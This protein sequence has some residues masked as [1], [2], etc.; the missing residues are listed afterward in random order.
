M[1]KGPIPVSVGGF[2]LCMAD[3]G[4]GLYAPWESIATTAAGLTS[5][6]VSGFD[7]SGFGYRE[8]E[9]TIARVDRVMP[10]TVMA[11]IY[12]QRSRAFE[13]KPTRIYRTEILAAV[14]DLA[15]AVELEAKL[16]QIGRET[17][18]AIEKKTAAARRKAEAQFQRV[19][20][21]ER[22]KALAKLR[23]LIPAVLGGGA[24]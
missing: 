10:K 23:K 12:N 14:E 24:A 16:L 13:V 1:T 18:A 22:K 3:L 7:L 15:G 17:D 9:L 5:A 20:D 11:T 8:H 6:D 21:R 19:A 4:R 2:V